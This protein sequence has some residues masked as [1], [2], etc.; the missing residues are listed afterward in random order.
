VLRV[1]TA[2]VDGGT[3]VAFRK[4]KQFCAFRLSPETAAGLVELVN[5]VYPA[6][7]SNKKGRGA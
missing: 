4:G 3:V 2:K 7:V 6:L 5:K 1:L